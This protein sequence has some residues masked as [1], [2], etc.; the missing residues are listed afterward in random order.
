MAG[1]ALYGDLYPLLISNQQVVL[2]HS[3]ES[4][5]ILPPNGSNPEDLLG[6]ITKECVARAELIG[7]DKKRFFNMAVTSD[8]VNIKEGEPV[9][10]L[11]LL[12][13]LLLEMK[14]QKN[15]RDCFCFRWKFKI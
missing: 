9:L 6:V 8:K 7:I 3:L 13:K 12:I 15:P 4:V 14:K 2:N 1:L 11:A 10:G 5:K